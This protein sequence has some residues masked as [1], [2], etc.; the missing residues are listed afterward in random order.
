MSSVYNATPDA[1]VPGGAVQVTNPDDGDVADAL[2]NN[3]A[4]EKLADLIKKLVDVAAFTGSDGVPSLTDEDSSLL[5][6]LGGTGGG[7]MRV[8][9]LDQGSAPE[10]WITVNAKRDSGNWVKDVDADPAAGLR[11]LGRLYLYTENSGGAFSAWEQIPGVGNA[12]AGLIS[13][14][15][16]T[17]PSFQNGWV[18]G[19]GGLSPCVFWKDALGMVHVEGSLSGGTINAEAFTLPATHRPDNDVVLIC[20]PVGAV[21]ANI[22]LRI[23]SAGVVTPTSPGDSGTYAGSIAFSGAFGV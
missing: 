21:P 18:D 20:T 7:Q 10:A 1:V 6:H 15:T 22:Y 11:Y 5:F 3:V 16:P 8:I 13:M 23:T 12:G 9:L 19:T 17:T 4:I 2:S 14:P